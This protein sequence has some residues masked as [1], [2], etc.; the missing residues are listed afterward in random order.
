MP[1][2]RVHDILKD[3]V[4]VSRESARLLEEP[5]AAMV[6]GAGTSVDAP[7]ASSVTVD[8][9]GVEGMAPSFLDELLSIFE[10]VIGRETNGHERSLIV[11]NPPARL[12][13][14]FE[15]VAR[16]HVMSVRALADGSWSLSELRNAGA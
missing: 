5:L 3:K 12:S 15:A 7:S 14:K 11:V 2:L 4:L 6:V 1:T 10:S 13:S 8:F 16:G 9:A